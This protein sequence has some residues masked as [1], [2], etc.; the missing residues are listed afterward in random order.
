MQTNNDFTKF[1]LK[2]IAG[3]VAYNPESHSF[4]L[5]L[6]SI[7]HSI[8]ETIY[9]EGRQWG[10]T[11]QTIDS[12]IDNAINN[13]GVSYQPAKQS[14]HLID[15]AKDIR[16]GVQIFLE[17]YDKSRGKARLSLLFLGISKASSPRFLVLGSTRLGLISED[18]VE[19]ADNTLWSVGHPVLFKVFRNERR[20]PDNDKVYKTFSIENIQVIRPSVIHEVIDARKE[21]TYTESLVEGLG[22]SLSFGRNPM[23]LLLHDYSKCMPIYA[24]FDE[25]GI[26]NY[27]SNP[28]TI[29]PSSE[30]RNRLFGIVDAG[31]KE[32]PLRIETTESG[33]LLL[34]ATD[35]QLKLKKPAKGRFISK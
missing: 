17:C 11:N 18:I 27:N 15:I 1:I 5:S 14:V 25:E 13:V 22:N 26:G 32:R 24:D 7:S 33:E 21:F 16:P 28:D 9:S 29:I 2:Q 35:M 31:Y 23:T 6:R 34:D 30:I 8:R 10:M 20:Y 4:Q 12:H 3:T 19:P